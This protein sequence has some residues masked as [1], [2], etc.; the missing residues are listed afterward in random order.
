MLVN[1]SAWQCAGLSKRWR[2]PYSRFRNL[3]RGSRHIHQL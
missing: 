2:N 3:P 1:S